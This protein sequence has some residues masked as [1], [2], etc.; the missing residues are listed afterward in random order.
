M[1]ISFKKNVAAYANGKIQ[2]MEEW[3]A[4]TGVASAAIEFGSPVIAA[5]GY[6]GVSPVSA[7]SQNVL[8]I[9]VMEQFLPH[10]GDE[11]HANDIV[12][13]AEQAVIGVKLG[14]DVTKGAQARYNV[15][16][17]NWSSASASATVL[18]IPG[19]QFDESGASGAIGLVRFRRPVPCVSAS[20]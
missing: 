18:T 6:D 4:T 17:K 7:A 15:T 19:A 5:D 12:T 8:G 13:I 3:N 11:Y 9:A 14:A 10:T 1:P 20:S 2:N 16:N